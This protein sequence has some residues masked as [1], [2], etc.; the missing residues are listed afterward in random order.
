MPRHSRAHPQPSQW[1]LQPS[2]P[3]P[4]LAAVPNLA[5]G[6]ATSSGPLTWPEC[7]TRW[8]GGGVRSKEA[9]LRSLQ[10]PAGEALRSLLGLHPGGWRGRDR[11]LVCEFS[12]SPARWT[13]TGSSSPWMFP[14]SQ[15]FQRLG[16]LLEKLNAAIREWDNWIQVVRLVGCKEAAP[17]DEYYLIGK[18]SPSLPF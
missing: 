14:F 13:Q 15:T 17:R 4:Q 2:N 8:A 10:S 9:R 1:V 16:D 11:D 6:T 5:N 12:L 18:V 7:H 3:L